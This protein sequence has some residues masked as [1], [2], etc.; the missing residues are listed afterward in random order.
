MSISGVGPYKERI[1]SATYREFLAPDRQPDNV[2]GSQRRRQ[3][4]HDVRVLVSSQ[5]LFSVQLFRTHEQNYL[6]G[7]NITIMWFARTS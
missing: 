4:Q 6:T 7:G 3:R 2:V 5:F 1:E